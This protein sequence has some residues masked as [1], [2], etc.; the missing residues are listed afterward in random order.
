[1][2]CHGAETDN[3]GAVQ[4]IAVFYRG[5]EMEVVVEIGHLFRNDNVSFVHRMPPSS[6]EPYASFCSAGLR[7]GVNR[8]WTNVRPKPARYDSRHPARSPSHHDQSLG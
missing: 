7:A 4:T 6:P 5:R 3:A 8:K 2:L 1:M